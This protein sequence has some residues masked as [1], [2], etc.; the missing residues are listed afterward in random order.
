MGALREYSSTAVCLRPSVRAEHRS[1]S[2]R[3]SRGLLCLNCD[4]ISLPRNGSSS[5]PSAPDAQRNWLHTGPSKTC[6]RFWK[7][8]H[9]APVTKIRLRPRSC[10]FLQIRPSLGRVRVIPNKFAAPSSRVQPTRS[11]DDGVATDRRLRFSRSDH[12]Q[13]RPLLLHGPPARRSRCQYSTR[14]Q[15]AL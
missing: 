10:D 6:R 9:S 12:R 1:P 4:R 3:K 8:A 7:P 14:L 15:G 5:P 11:V 2:D 13:S